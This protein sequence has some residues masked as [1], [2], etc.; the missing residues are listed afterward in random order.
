MLIS[1]VFKIFH[2]RSIEIAD[3]FF[4]NLITPLHPLHQLFLFN[5]ALF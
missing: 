1:N 5:I 4:L 3:S 2:H